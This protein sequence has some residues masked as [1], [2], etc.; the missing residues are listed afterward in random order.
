MSL[1]IRL[2]PDI[3]RSVAFGSLSAVYIG[4][5]TAMTKPI[6]MMILQN[7]TDI[8]VMFSFDGIHDTLPL[9]SN[10]YLV[11]DI[12]SNKTIDQ[13]FFLAQ[14]SRIY[15]KNLIPTDVATRHAVYLTTF[16]AAEI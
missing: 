10:G 9:P 13:G 15:V 6:R 12:T 1:A 7:F 14:G 2:V 11:L 4:M 16:Y 3:L 5:G 8:N